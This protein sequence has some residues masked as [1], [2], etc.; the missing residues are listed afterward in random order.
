MNYKESKWQVYRSGYKEVKIS[1]AMEGPVALLDLSLRS[2]V[3]DLYDIWL[4]CLRNAV[5]PWCCRVDDFRGLFF[6]FSLI[7]NC[8]S[9][10]D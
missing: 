1:Y 5:L 6:I 8:S 4:T 9:S 2:T 7:R 10:A 3:W